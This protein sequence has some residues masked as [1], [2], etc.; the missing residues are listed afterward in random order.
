MSNQLYNV[1]NYQPKNIELHKNYIM[2][3]RFTTILEWS[4]R[5]LNM[6]LLIIPRVKVKY[7]FPVSLGPL[8]QMH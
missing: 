1:K 7:P 2:F 4:I 3:E 6:R 5:R 8:S